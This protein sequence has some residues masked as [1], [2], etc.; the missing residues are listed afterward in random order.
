MPEICGFFGVSIYMYYNDYNQRPPHFHALYA[1][2][3]A[4]SRT[5]RALRLKRAEEVRQRI[6]RHQGDLSDLRQRLR[7]RQ[8][9][10]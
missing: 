4:L 3:E 8:Q 7:S 1:K 5:Y 10:N 9:G 6:E 2:H